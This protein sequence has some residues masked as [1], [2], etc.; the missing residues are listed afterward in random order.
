MEPRGFKKLAPAPP[1]PGTETQVSL[2]AQGTRRNITRNACSP[3]KNKKAKCDGNRPE[4]GRCQKNGDT[5]LYEVNRRDISRLQLLSDSDSARLQS[6]DMIFAILQSG[7][8]EQAT[9]LLAQIRLGETAETLAA[10][11]G[12]SEFQQSTS[13]SY[14][15]SSVLHN[16]GP[17]TTCDDSE[18]PSSTGMTQGFLDLLDRND[19]SQPAE[20]TTSYNHQTTDG[21]RDDF[22]PSSAHATH[23]HSELP[24]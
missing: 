5:C 10:T 19:W 12:L 1:R 23:S 6:L 18:D 16:P 15:T 24:Y 8:N 3:C 11:F 14:D 13:V 2:P 17:S 20:A 22:V 9:E 4:C 21:E 7:T